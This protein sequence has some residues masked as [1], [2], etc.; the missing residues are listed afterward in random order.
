MVIQRVERRRAKRV[1]GCSRE[2]AIERWSFGADL[3]SE[4]LPRESEGSSLGVLADRP[5]LSRVDH[6]PTECLDPFQRLGD[7]AH[8][9][10]RQGEGIAGA[11]P[12]G[13]DADRWSSRVRLPALSLSP[14]AGLQ[15]EAEELHPEASG[16]L[17]IV[18]GK[19]DE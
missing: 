16:A 7:V 9:E 6:A 8:R 17:G 18:G 14:L 12:A 1:A 3:P 19:F 10:V 15:L 2:E 13:M 11:A 4:R 5:R